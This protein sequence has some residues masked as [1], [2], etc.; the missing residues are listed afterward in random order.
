MAVAKLSR[1]VP[2]EAARTT[3]YATFEVTPISPHIGAEIRG[4]DLADLSDA[5][6]A[7]VRQAWADWSV[8]VFRDQHLSREAHKAFGRQFGA[9]HTHP[10]HHSRP[11]HDPEILVVKTTAESRYTAG[12]TWHTDVSCDP[13]PPLGSLLYITE[14]P[15]CGGGD[16][17]FADMYMAYEMLSPPMQAF[18]EGL[19]AVHDGAM[20][21]VGNYR[22]TAPEGGY[23]RTLHPVVT[24]H[25]V[26]GR[27]VLYVNSGFTTHI[28]GLQRFES[29]AILDMCFELLQREAKL[30]C[31]VRWEPNTL[32]MWDN[33]CTQHQAVWD[34]YPFSRYG[35]RVSVVGQEPPRA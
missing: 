26:T 13:I 14:T 20:P 18:L 6:L 3:R 29:R 4:L 24:R 16:T 17:L 28:E 2:I 19:T 21:Y 32:T 35:E 34:Y 11:D 22:S 23:P 33:R 5:Q 25:P 27:K 30:H 12:E 10:M 1:H 8:L 31:R 7:D 9:L 15:E